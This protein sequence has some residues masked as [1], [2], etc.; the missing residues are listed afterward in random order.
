M[1][2]AM[3]IKVFRNQDVGPVEMETAGLHRVHSTPNTTLWE[4]KRPAKP[5]E[6]PLDSDLWSMQG[7]LAD[8]VHEAARRRNSHCADLVAGPE[9]NAQHWL[10][11]LL[12][13]DDMAEIY[14]ERGRFLNS[15]CSFVLEKRALER[16]CQSGN[17]PPER[18]A[19][20][21][22]DCLGTE[23]LDDLCLEMEFKPSSRIF[24]VDS[25][26]LTDTGSQS[27]EVNLDNLDEYLRKTLEFA[28]D[29][30]IRKQMEAFVTGFERVFPV[31]WLALFNGPELSHLISGDASVSWTREE[32]LMYT[33][34]GRGYS[35]S[36]PTYKMLIDVLLQMNVK[37]RR[38]F[39][40][41]TTGSSTLPI[42]GL[43]NLQP[44]IQVVRKELKDSGPYPSVNT[45]RHYLKLPPYDT[46]EELK[47]RLMAATKEIGFYLN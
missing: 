16:R 44:H 32:L 15:V 1:M 33:L 6:D 13:L 39:L 45:C 40:R 11:G 24:G 26:P 21:A 43:K 2:V 7:Y 34:P 9:P 30:G 31:A 12:D 38:A 41:F 4:D 22:L 29:E 42:G 35:P 28:L 37:E 3:R 20:L 8:P 27:R 36:S 5:L 18:L 19:S 14:P 47:A 23:D 46:P 17:V 10:T 25:Y